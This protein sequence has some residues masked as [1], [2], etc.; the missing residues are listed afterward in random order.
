MCNLL[1]AAIS[2][3]YS[4]FIL[5]QILLDV[6]ESSFLKDL[7]VDRTLVS[8]CARFNFSTELSSHFS[9]C[10]RRALFHWM[11]LEKYRSDLDVVLL[12][13]LLGSLVGRISEGRLMVMLPNWSNSLKGCNWEWASWH[14][15]QVGA[16]DNAAKVLRFLVLVWK[17]WHH[18]IPSFLVL[19]IMA[20]L[21]SPPWK[22]STGDM[23]VHS[24]GTRFGLDMDIYVLNSNGWRMSNWHRP[25]NHMTKYA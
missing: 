11:H 18:G 8:A 19:I 7:Y 10:A 20:S 23:Q 3:S 12:I 13:A 2:C 6:F 22:I 1:T 5:E 21:E 16:V 15:S 4:E 24:F 14:K 25:L 9:K 17:I